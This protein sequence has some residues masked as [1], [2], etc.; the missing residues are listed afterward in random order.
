M[1]SLSTSK[2]AKPAMLL[3]K[4]P[5]QDMIDA[6]FQ[7]SQTPEAHFCGEHERSGLS[8]HVPSVIANAQTT[9]EGSTIS[10]ST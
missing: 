3:G 9:G 7:S 6:M 8:S 10:P 1:L 2:R 5:R 4:S